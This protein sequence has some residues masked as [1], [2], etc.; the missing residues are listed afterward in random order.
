M[1][2][3]ADDKRFY[4]ELN[5]SIWEYFRQ[6]IT[7][8]G[9]GISKPA[10]VEFLKSSGVESTVI[11]D[12]ISVLQDC[13]TSMYTDTMPDEPKERL[14]NKTRSVLKTIEERLK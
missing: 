1:M 4:K 9:S 7:I 6:K 3:A 8:S 11:I 12:L 14:F 2:V 10:L 5:K 13:E